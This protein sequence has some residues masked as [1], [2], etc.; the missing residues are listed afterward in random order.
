MHV[1]KLNPTIYHS[2]LVSCR[3]KAVI[4]TQ[5]QTKKKVLSVKSNVTGG[6]HNRSVFAVGSVVNLI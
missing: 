5:K 3:V 2:V 1:V 6:A 4:I